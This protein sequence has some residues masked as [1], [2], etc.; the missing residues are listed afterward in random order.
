[1]RISC[2]NC[3]QLFNFYFKSNAFER[4]KKSSPETALKN[5]QL[6]NTLTLIKSEELFKLGWCYCATIWSSKN[7]KIIELYKEISPGCQQHMRGTGENKNS[8]INLGNLQI[9]RQE[10][11]RRKQQPTPV[12]LPGESQGWGSLVGCTEI[13]GMGLHR[14]GH[15]WSDLVAGKKGWKPDLKLRQ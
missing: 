6:F 12:F 1:M 11:W 3:K 2:L 7:L 13:P 9:S 10:G 8:K 14:V 5:I 4:K 15:D